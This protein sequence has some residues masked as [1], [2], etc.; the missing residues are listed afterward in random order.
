MKKQTRTLLILGALAAGGYYLY[1]KGMI[2]GL[3]A[4]TAGTY[5]GG[6]TS[7]MI[8]LS[9][10]FGGAVKTSAKTS[11]RAAATGGTTPGAGGGTVSG[12]EKYIEG[13]LP[14]GTR[15]SPE[16]A[17]PE[18]IAARYT[19]TPWPPYQPVLTQ[20]I[21]PFKYFGYQHGLT[22]P[23]GPTAAEKADI[24]A[25]A[26]IRNKVMAEAGQRAAEAAR[27]AQ[28]AQ[29]LVRAIRHQEEQAAAYTPTEVWTP[30]QKKNWEKI[31]SHQARIASYHI[32]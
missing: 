8:D 26:K 11:I 4:P 3:G 5:G 12:V 30:L 9:K 32:V 29:S 1:R 23:G 25:A 7:T 19:P 27:K 31:V 2:P 28:S 6:G 20:P 22:V 21:T 10:L 14:Y 16:S 18:H 13:K 24:V 17:I 15:I